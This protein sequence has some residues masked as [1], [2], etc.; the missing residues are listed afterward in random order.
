VLVAATV[1]VVAVSVAVTAL[2]FSPKSWIAFAAGTLLVGLT[3]GCIG[4]LSG[5]LLGQLGATYLVLFRG[6]TR[7]GDSAKPDV[8]KWHA[9][10]H[11]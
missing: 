7:S 9:A 10:W 2:S 11:R 5:A 3:Y 6:D 4:V 1:I 8:R